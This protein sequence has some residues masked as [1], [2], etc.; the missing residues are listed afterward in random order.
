[1]IARRVARIIIT[2][3]PF[4]ASFCLAGGAGDW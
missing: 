1:M 3:L 2:S 4:S